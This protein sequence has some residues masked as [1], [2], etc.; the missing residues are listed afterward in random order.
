MC[1]D[2]ERHQRL[3]SSSPYPN[4]CLERSQEYEGEVWRWWGGKDHYRVVM[5]LA[6]SA[7]HKTRLGRTV[8]P[9]Y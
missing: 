8:V 1:V 2:R 6:N 9:W 3:A 7:G 5:E 4:A